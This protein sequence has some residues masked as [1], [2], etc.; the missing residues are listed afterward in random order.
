MLASGSEDDTIKL[1]L[2]DQRKEVATLEGHFRYMDSVAFSPDGQI[3]A[4]GSSDGLIRLWDV[5]TREQIAILRKRAE[6]INSV[7]FSPDGETLATASYGDQLQLWDIATKRKKAT[8][9]LA[10]HTSEVESIAFSPDGQTLASGGYMDKVRLWDIANRR[11]VAVLESDKRVRTVMYSPSG[12]ILAMGID[13]PREGGSYL[14][15]TTGEAHLWDAQTLELITVLE[16]D[17][18]VLSIAFSPDGEILATASGS[19]NDVDD[20]SMGEVRL[21]NMQTYE[22]LAT[23]VQDE[24]VFSIAFSPDGKMIAAGAEQNLRLWNVATQQLISSV[25]TGDTAGC[26][27]FSPD[28]QTLALGL[29]VSGGPFLW[30]VP[31]GE[32]IQRLRAPDKHLYPAQSLSFSPNG[33]ILASKHYNTIRLWDMETTIRLWDKETRETEA[34]LEAPRVSVV[35]FSPDGLTLASGNSGGTIL[36]WDTS[37]FTNMDPITSIDPKGKMVFKWG[38]VKKTELLQNYPNP[39]NPETWIPY[40]LASDRNVAIK[41]YNLSGEIVRVLDIGRRESGIYM[42][43]ERAAYWDG[44]DDQDQSVASGIYFYQLVAGDIHL[45]AK[46]MIIVR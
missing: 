29:Q 13:T 12:K 28:G 20:I 14:A 31:N 10:G 25:R 11:Q 42:D 9:A 2:V 34:I 39:F 46:K 43:Q 16:H 32:D 24:I 35:R 4:S 21:W 33:K 40:Q 19:Y 3:L 1:W 22:L 17:G 6:D 37:S 41:I 44:R 38:E 18:T 45:A 23:L 15:N 26:M 30:E 7:A 8:S 5:Q 27:E 36:L